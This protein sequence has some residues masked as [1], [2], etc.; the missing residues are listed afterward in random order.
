MSCE[1]CKLSHVH[2]QIN[3]SKKICLCER[4]FMT[5]TTMYLSSCLLILVIKT[6][7]SSA[8]W[9]IVCARINIIWML[10]NICSNLSLLS[11]IK[12]PY[13]NLFSK[14]VFL[15]VFFI[16]GS[17]K[18]LLLL[19]LLLLKQVKNQSSCWV[20]E[21]L[22]PFLYYYVKIRLVHGQEWAFQAYICFCF[23]CASDDPS[24]ESPISIRTCC[25]YSSNVCMTV[26]DNRV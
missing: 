7:I 13:L 4:D 26:A 21:L 20:S 5:E 19:L 23:S 17:N 9:C 11:I 18:E 10:R 16:I 1:I 3:S 2:E 15:I 24:V 6:L 25:W 12:C 8:L 22:N 14:I